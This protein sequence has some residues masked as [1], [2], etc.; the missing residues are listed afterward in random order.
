M[1][2]ANNAEEQQNTSLGMEGI[3]IKL[4]DYNE[5]SHPKAIGGEKAEG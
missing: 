5:A 1:V 3:D 2:E 4:E